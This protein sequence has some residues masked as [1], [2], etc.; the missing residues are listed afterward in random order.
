MGFDLASPQYD[1]LGR[2]V[3][4]NQAPGSSYDRGSLLFVNA[5]GQFEE[6]GADPASIAAVSATSAGT[7]TSGL[8]PFGQKGFP[9]GKMQGHTVRGKRFLADYVGALPAADGGLYGVVD[10]ATYG[11]SV[12]FAEVAATRVRL[13]GRRTDSPENVRK[14]IVEFVSN[15]Q[16]V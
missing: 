12:D 8:N 10:D 1:G 14:V 13:V 15:I 2:T 4:R 9:P 6:C 3:E 16:D 5:S 11:W 7:D